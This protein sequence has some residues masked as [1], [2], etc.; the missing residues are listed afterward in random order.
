MLSGFQWDAAK[1]IL[2]G[3]RE[4]KIEI[5]ER[6]QER[7]WSAILT[8]FLVSRVIVFALMLLGSFISVSSTDEIRA[9]GVPNDIRALKVHRVPLHAALSNLAFSA[10]GDR[11]HQ[12]ASGGYGSA[13]DRAFFPGFPLTWH[14]A[15]ML[16]REYPVTGLLISNTC[17]LVALWVLYLLCLEIG[18]TSGAAERA[19]FYACFFPVS[20]FFSLPFTESLFTLLSVG[21]VYL[22]LREKWTLAGIVGIGATAT[23]LVGLMLIPTLALI[24]W[25]KHR[26]L[27]PSIVFTSVPVLGFAGF[28]AFLYAV[29]GDALGFLHAQSSFGHSVQWGRAF[30]HYLSVPRM[31][32]FTPWHFYPLHF[33]SVLIACISIVALIWRR[34]IPLAVYLFGC[35]VIPLSVDL[36]SMTRY[37]MGSFPLF[38]GIS[39]LTENQRV[40]LCVRAIFIS[41]LA[42]MSLAYGFR[43]GFAMT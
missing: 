2:G 35:L 40:D 13:S 33:A 25:Q 27:S 9:Q 32:I 41:L 36:A 29:H 38:I 20:H 6:I 15:A 42:I 21:A 24:W 37:T 22:A 14:V 3:N 31:F 28:C 11:Y 30:L 7:K 34:N 8:P 23:R 1:Y 10:D 18:C 43:F 5:S 12:I 39:Y 26:R 16:T 4:V 17:F 19:V